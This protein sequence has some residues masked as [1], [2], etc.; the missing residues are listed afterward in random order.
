MFMRIGI[1]FYLLFFSGVLC[2]SQPLLCR[3]FYPNNFLA[4]PHD[5]MA[6]A[7]YLSAFLFLED[8]K[9]AYILSLNSLTESPA[10]LHYQFSQL[11]HNIPVKNAGIKVNVAKTGKIISIYSNWLENSPS[12]V[13][14]VDDDIREKYIAEAEKYLSDKGTV[15]DEQR[16]FVYV[17][18]NNKL[19]LFLQLDFREKS[20]LNKEVLVGISGVFSEKITSVFL[21]LDSVVTGKVFNPDPLTTAQ[22]VYGGA[23]IDNNDADAPVLNNE[24]QSQTFTADFD[25]TVFRL[26]NDFIQ[27][28]DINGNGI[29]PVTSTIPIFDFTRH[30]SG[31]EDVN[32]FYHLSKFRKYVHDLGFNSANGLAIIDPHGTNE[33]NSFFSAPNNL[34]FGTGGVDDAEDADVLIH[35]YLHFISYRSAPSSNIGFERNSLDEGIADYF[36]ASYSKRL[37]DYNAGWV[38][39]WDGH[40]EFWNGRVVNS[41]KHYPEDLSSTSYY[42]NAELWSS[43]LM[44]I[45]GDLGYAYTDSLVL[46]VLYFFAPNM[47]QPQAAKAL[48]LC[49][50]LLNNGKNFCTLYKHLYNRGY[51][52]FQQN[53]CGI[54]AIHDEEK[55]VPA[56]LFYTPTG[57][58]IRANNDDMQIVS[59]RILNING[60]KCYSASSALF[61]E[62]ETLAHGMYIVT[63]STNKGMAI[64]KW[65]NF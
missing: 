29:Q 24:R 40:N 65:V 38:Y 34:I 10:A 8:P 3:D 62:K 39:N 7:D 18:E 46:N 35:E 4:K 23:Y 55:S 5:T 50:T 47:T 45:H 21:G 30:E 56:E 15:F 11:F 54:T 42:R 32:T 59:Y 16:M 9:N 48:L 19:S 17:N 26:Q 58:V 27:L 60:Q 14:F 61:S 44:D 57:F 20:G 63:V 37:S 49:D 6:V 13:D 28:S 43:A 53:S 2:R 51:L 1:L 12:S 33:D 64:L 52:P 22:V 31:F 25:G 41:T 36:A